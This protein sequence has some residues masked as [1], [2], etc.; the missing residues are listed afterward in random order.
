MVF[1]KICIQSKNL[2]E[3]AQISR[4]IP[5]MPYKCRKKIYKLKGL[6][7]DQNYYYIF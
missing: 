2:S 7:G 5:S 4:Y 3:M 6:K 1:A